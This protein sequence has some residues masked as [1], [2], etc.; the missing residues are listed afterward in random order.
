MG[1]KKATSVI[2]IVEYLRIIVVIYNFEP[3]KF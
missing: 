2:N 1:C 3:T